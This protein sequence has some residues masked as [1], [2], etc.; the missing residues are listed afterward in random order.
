MLEWR[1]GS[2]NI[3]PRSGTTNLPITKTAGSQLDEVK[4]KFL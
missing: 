3:N 4:T 1:I 2:L